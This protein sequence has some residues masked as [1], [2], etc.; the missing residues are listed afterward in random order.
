REAGE[1]L[2]PLS[3]ALCSSAFLLLDDRDH[4]VRDRDFREADARVGDDPVVD[5]AELDGG[6]DLGQLPGLDAFESARE[7]DETAVRQHLAASGFDDGDLQLPAIAVDGR[8]AAWIVGMIDEGLL[9]RPEDDDEH[10]LLHRLGGPVFVEAIL[11]SLEESPIG[12]EE[13][14]GI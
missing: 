12:L 4:W 14:H 11:P 1:S 5:G 3:S 7:V 8:G 6:A 10:R 9:V 13:D 2:S